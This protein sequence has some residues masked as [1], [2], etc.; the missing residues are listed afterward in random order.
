M[1]T[2]EGG[3]TRNDDT[4]KLATRRFLSQFAIQRYFEYMHKHRMQADGTMRDGDNWK[5]GSGIPQDVYAD[6]LDR[7]NHDIKSIL[8][9]APVRK[10]EDGTPIDIEGVLCAILFNAMGMLHELVKGLQHHH[11]C[12]RAAHPQVH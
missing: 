8:A 11:R 5:K 4:D 12:A 6:S 9:G 3:A 10:N 7:H 2:F 1:R